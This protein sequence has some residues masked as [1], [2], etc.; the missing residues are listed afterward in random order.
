MTVCIQFTSF[1]F[2]Y[3]FSPEIIPCENVSSF[4]FDGCLRSWLINLNRS[5]FFLSFFLCC[6]LMLYFLFLHIYLFS[7]SRNNF[8]SRIYMLLENW[9]LITSIHHSNWLRA[10]WYVLCVYMTIHVIMASSPSSSSMCKY[11]LS[12]VFVNSVGNWTVTLFGFCFG[13]DQRDTIAKHE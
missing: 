2:I 13:F 1:I 12:I 8:F 6:I 10:E 7:F 4:G 9:C 11:V 5:T 3:H